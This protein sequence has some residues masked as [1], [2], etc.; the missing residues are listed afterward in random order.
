MNL[1]NK[2]TV[3][4]F[5]LTAAFVLAMVSEIPFHE[6]LAL[7]LFVA[8][9]ITDLLDGR[10]A[11]RD[12][13]ITNFGILMDPL[14]D[15]ILV[16]AGFIAF[17]DEAGFPRGWPSSSWRVNSPSPACGCW[18]RPKACPGGGKCRQ[19]QDHLADHRHRLGAGHRGLR[20]VGRGE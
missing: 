17:V 20:R 8:A 4:R 11:R 16:C 9:A 14:A 15:K 6:T 13:L 5:G 12:K 10:I 1:P 19:A 2:L 3:S 18:Q 7:A